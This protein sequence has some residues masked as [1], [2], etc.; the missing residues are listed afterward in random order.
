MNTRSTD[1]VSTG[2]RLISASRS[3]ATLSLLL[4]FGIQVSPQS[5][6]QTTTADVV[7][8]V[9]DSS[10]GVLPNAK[11]TVENLATHGKYAAQTTSSGDYDVPFVLPGHYSIRVELAGFKTFSVADS[12]IA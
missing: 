1:L 12:S 5:K 9:T 8:N 10:G 7:G 11:V 4:L 2:R 3:A 6:A